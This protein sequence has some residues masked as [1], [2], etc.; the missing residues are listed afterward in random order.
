MRT[1][2]AMVPPIHRSVRI[3]A[4]TATTAIRLFYPGRNKEQGNLCVLDSD[5]DGYGDLEPPLPYEPGTDCNDADEPS[6]R[7]TRCL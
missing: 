2:T 4:Q 3:L 6:T 5:G 1:V 7:S